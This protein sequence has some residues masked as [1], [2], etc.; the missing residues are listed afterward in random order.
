MQHCLEKKENPLLPAKQAAEKQQGESCQRGVCSCTN[1]FLYEFP[2]HP[3]ISLRKRKSASSSFRTVQACYSL[4]R[5]CHVLFDYAP[6]KSI[7]PSLQGAC[8][9][10]TPERGTEHKG[11]LLCLL[12][13]Q[14]QREFETEVLLS[15]AGVCAFNWGLS[16]LST[17]RRALFKSYHSRSQVSASVA[18][19]YK[20]VTVHNDSNNLFSLNWTCK[21]SY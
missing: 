7:A 5:Q 2:S 10:I 1:H 19:S 6:L 18:I 15:A 14:E 9:A 13:R 3:I 21:T 17:E 11:W 16:H 12:I 20:T 4:W 8:H